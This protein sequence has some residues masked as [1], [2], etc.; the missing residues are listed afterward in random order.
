MYSD[1]AVVEFRHRE[2]NILKALLTHNVYDLGAHDK[3]KI[4]VALCTQMMTYATARDH[5]EDGF[6]R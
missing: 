6:D 2:P 3:L 5:M 4:L 1:D